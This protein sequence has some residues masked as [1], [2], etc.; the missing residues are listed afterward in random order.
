[1]HK[2]INAASTHAWSLWLKLYRSIDDRGHLIS[3]SHRYLI[4]SSTTIPL[5]I[6][7]PGYRHWLLLDLLSMFFLT[8]SFMCSVT[9]KQLDGVGAPHPST[10]KLPS[11]YPALPERFHQVCVKSRDM[12]QFG[13]PSRAESNLPY[14]RLGVYSVYIGV[15]SFPKP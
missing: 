9:G 13:P 1:M 8:G 10:A 3:S 7:T 11:P 6:A 2:C 14:M 12:P 15:W 4:D 5:S